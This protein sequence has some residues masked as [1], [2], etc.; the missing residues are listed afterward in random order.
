[1]TDIFDRKELFSVLNV[2]QQLKSSMFK[3][4]Q[5][6][7]ET[8]C[9]QKPKLRTLMTFKDFQ[10]LPPHIY[11]PLSFAERR[12]ISKVRMGILPLRLE[13]ARYS[14]PVIPEEQRLCYCSSGKVESESY[15]LFECNMY[16]ELRTP[17]LSSLYLPDNLNELEQCEKL[18]LVLNN[19][20][21][22][23]L[24]AKYIIAAMNLRSQLIDSSK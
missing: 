4:Q 6:M 1:M 24:T 14:R 15:L 21:N 7:V 23:R 5:E 2:S 10:T 9:A 11:K 20:L 8:E 17:W 3:K 12:I 18:K 22:V 16:T 13:T 19:P